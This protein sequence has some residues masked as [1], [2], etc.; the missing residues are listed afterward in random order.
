MQLLAISRWAVLVLSVTV[1]AKGLYYDPA[2]LASETGKT[3]GYQTY[4]TIGCPGRQLL[5]APCV[6][7]VPVDRDRDGVPD[8]RDKCPAT[9]PGRPV[10]ARG[11]E[12]DSDGDGLLDSKDACPNVY[13]KTADGCPPASP[14]QPTSIPQKLLLQGVGFDNDQ[15]TL[16]PDALP[17]LDQAAATLKSWGALKVEVAGYTDSMNDDAHNLALSGDRANAVRNYL[18]GKGVAAERLIAKGHGKENP[19]ADNATEAGRAQ[20]RRV[21]LV[22][23]R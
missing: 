1:K 8:D 18:I 6:K 12:I 13:A 10:D 3:T 11:C 20:N 17:I 22:P 15:A 21:E 7:P 5:D 14:A 4:L 16:R 19:I 9:R 2:N 23:Q